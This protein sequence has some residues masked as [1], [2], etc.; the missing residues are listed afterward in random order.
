MI[1]DTLMTNPVIQSMTGILPN[2]ENASG[3][4][5][6]APRCGN[7]N[8]SPVIAAY[9]AEN[10]TMLVNSTPI[11][12]NI[13]RGAT[14]YVWKIDGNIVSEP[15]PAF[16]NTGTYQVTLEASDGTNT[17]TTTSQFNIVSEFGCALSLSLIH[18]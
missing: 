15:L 13:S 3:A 8:I 6:Y 5:F 10:Y 16:A 18:I 17:S 1:S 7:I 4:S 14:T 9:T 2:Y 11:I 12:T